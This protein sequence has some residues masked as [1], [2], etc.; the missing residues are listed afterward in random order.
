MGKLDLH[1]HIVPDG[2]SKDRL[3]KYASA[4]DMISHLSEL[5][6]KKGVLMSGGETVSCLKKGPVNDEVQAICKKYP[7]YYAWM[8]N[9]D[10]RDANTV[11]ERLA[12]YKSNG[13]VGIGE[14]MINKHI[15][16]PFV[17]AVFCAAEKLN[18][19]ITIH[20][21]S[22]EGYKYGLVDEPGLPLLEKALTNHPDLKII[23]HSQV[24]WIEISGDAPTDK[25][26]RY[27][28]GKGPVIP[29]GRLPDLFAKH[30]NLYG[31]LSANSAGK[32]I[33]R[34]PLFGL[35]FL[36]TYSDRLF[37]ATDM[38]TTDTVYPLSSW[39]DEQLDNGN[40][41]QDTYD[42]ICFK[43]AERIFGL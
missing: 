19:P 24:F 38:L 22:A 8:C 16:S 6:I 2:S 23:G 12:T 5:G 3:E 1:L 39:L 33:M 32:A 11:Y 30:L 34:D 35:Q 14:F 25:E 10:E 4:T 27:K 42:K 15:D 37:F 41:S 26:S 40:L 13:A 21:S 7:Q 31:D 17:E 29:G 43:N 36:E 28:A 9:L 18:L 20:M